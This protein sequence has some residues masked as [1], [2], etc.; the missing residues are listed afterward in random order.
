MGVVSI[1]TFYNLPDLR[2][3]THDNEFIVNSAHLLDGFSSAL[4]LENPEIQGRPTFNLYIWFAFKFCGQDPARYHILQTGLHL[5]ASLLLALCVRRLGGAF[6][7]SLIAG[8]LFLMNVA[9]FRAVHW[10][11]ATGYILALLCGLMV[12]WMN[13]WALRTGQNKWLWGTIP[14][15]VAAVFA[16]PSLVVIFCLYAF[17]S[18]QYGRPLKE[19]FYR[20][21][22]QLLAT[23]ASMAPILFLF[24]DTPQ[25]RAIVRSPDFIA[26]L[27]NLFWFWG[28]QLTT[29]HW[30]PESLSL[31]TVHSWELGIGALF[32]ACSVFFALRSNDSLRLWTFWAFCF[33]LP[34]LT[35]DMGDNASGPSRYLYIASAG[36]TLILT[37]ALIGLFRWLPASLRP[38]LMPALLVLLV[39][40]SLRSLKEAEAVSFYQ[41]G[42]SYIAQ[43]DIETG[44]RQ[45]ESAVTHNPRRVPVDG[46]FRLAAASFASGIS[47]ED[48]FQKARERL[49]DDPHLDILIHLSTL[50]TGKPENWASVEHQIQNI[51]NTGDTSLLEKAARAY[52][53]L[54]SFYLRSD[55]L[56]EA[57]YL[58]NRVLQLQPNYAVALKNLGIALHNQGKLG[59]AID[60]FRKAL[61]LQP[62]DEE[63]IVLLSGDTVVVE[64][65]LAEMLYEQ[66][67]VEAAILS[68]RSLIQSHPNETALLEK[69]ANIHYNRGEKDTALQLYQ[70]MVRLAPN[71][72]E[73]YHRM[74]QIYGALNHKKEEKKTYRQIVE[75]DAKDARAWQ[76]LGNVAYQ[77]GN[78]EDAV[79]AYQ[80][81]VQLSPQN[82]TGLSNLAYLLMRQ[83]RFEEA[84]SC[85]RQAISLAPKNLKNHLALGQALEKLG[86]VVEAIE[87]YRRVLELDNHNA[88]AQN[89]IRTLMF[90]SEKP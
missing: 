84:V 29:A 64:R 83:N 45:F 76:S 38:Y 41:S 15:V 51:L 6:E 77:M 30:L 56:N 21:A 68:Y 42:R 74:A 72:T 36:T 27:H 89:R 70:N 53:N 10:I 61:V 18:W 86:K 80:R 2:F 24:S 90:D 88:T 33:T 3:D 9:H 37:S 48:V 46:Y 4:F 59:P 69:L 87:T 26:P 32:I 43:G 8:L 50:L 11:S 49:P 31:S 14:F 73:F 65:R 39:F 13:H 16:H 63:L 35:A 25:T 79:A 85:Y 23:L 47:P 71:Q 5:L 62:D 7:L 78:T 40:S 58:Y 60:A 54:G 81:V 55:R 20:T 1:L 66:G 67:K 19:T 44:T 17:M 52:F 12:L 28:R 57:E 22:P 34:F 82:P 75:L